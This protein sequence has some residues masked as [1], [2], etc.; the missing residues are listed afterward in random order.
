MSNQILIFGCNGQLGKAI[1]DIFPDGIKY[2]RSECDFNN[3]EDISKC[4]LRIKPEV[5][6]N[7]AAYTDVNHSE[8]DIKKALK[9]NSIAVKAIALSA[10]IVDALVIHFS[11]DYVF[12]GSNSSSYTENSPTYPINNYG[13]TKLKG[14]KKL[15]KFNDKHIIIRTSWVYGQGKNNFVYKVI[16]NIQQKKKLAVVDYEFGSPTQ[17]KS[18]AFI[19]K[20]FIDKYFEK[21]K[22]KLEYGIY[23]FSGNVRIS[24]YTFAKKIIEIIKSYNESN[25]I[26]I[27]AI[28]YK[29]KSKVR[30]PLNS[31]L[32]CE[33]ICKYL[34]IELPNWEN[35]LK[36]FFDNNYRTLLKNDK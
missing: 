19:V 23:N 18:L 10:N 28:S 15:V 21:S 22:K 13:K 17:T 32:N 2:S 31:F 20:M 25:D 33:K 1:S 11:T 29:L 6:I 7:C 26:E 16:K 27:T 35:Q 8:I 14:E 24:R 34:D 30:R 5:I 9:I 12:D 3:P 4:I 36:D